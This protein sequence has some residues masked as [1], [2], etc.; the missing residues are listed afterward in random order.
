M[1]Q[2]PA[3][4]P[5]KLLLLPI[6]LEEPARPPTKKLLKPPPDAPVLQDQILSFVLIKNTHSPSV[7]QMVPSLLM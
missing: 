2:K 7:T 3:S 4:H 1:L 5:K 6:M